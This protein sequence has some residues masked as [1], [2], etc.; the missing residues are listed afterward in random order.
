M[1]RSCAM[2]KVD[3]KNSL[4]TGQELM[5]RHPN[6]KILRQLIAA[7]ATGCILFLALAGAQQS[8]KGGGRTFPFPDHL[9]MDKAVSVILGRASDTSV[10]VNL[11]AEEAVEAFLEYGSESG[12]Y[13]QKTMPITLVKN[14]P[15]ETTLRGLK[16]NTRYVYRLQTR[17]R[18][19]SYEA[20]PEC[21]F[22][23]Q[24]LPGSEFVFC[25]QG[26]SHPERPNMS[27]PNL[28]ARTLQHASSC[29]PDLYF[30]MGD[31]FSVSHVRR[32]DD[33]TLAA[34]Y[35]LQR[36]FLG[37]VAKSASLYLVNGNHEQAS[38]FNYNQTDVRRQVAIGV[39]NARNKLFPM[40]ATEGI[41]T[42][43]AQQFEGIGLLRD[44]Y[45][46][47]WGDSLFV[48]LDNYWHSPAQVDSGF[49][50]AAE[51]GSGKKGEDKK[52]EKKN[53]DKRN[54]D[55][56]GISLGD[57]QYRWFKKTLETSNAKFKFVFAHHVLGTGR[58]GVEMSNLYEW[59]GKSKS[60]TNEFKQ[61][62][63]NWELPI[64]P[65]MVKHGVTIFFHGHDH[66]FARQ[67]R[68]GVIY[69][70]A[71]LPADP[72]YATHNDDAYT[73]T[74][75]ANSG[76]LRVTVSPERTKV[77]YVRCWLPKDETATQKTGHI[78]HSY[79]IQAKGK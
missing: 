47:T 54:R 29:R 49:D 67:E 7:I 18:D 26:D 45:A 64:H 37:L 16:P 69:Q 57:E 32:V 60:G 25:V 33:I 3:I 44:Y 17:K 41:Y 53:T 63:P 55:W 52:A 76:Y 5:D 48:V 68:D 61:K 14:Q 1:R 74:K 39:Q 73:G 34:P 20:R 28:Y 30:C 11:L 66:L 23:T 36:P 2:A 46:W 43:D 35:L 22:H 75:L 40:P 56:W 4:D 59:G 70:E 8:Q 10:T 50:L 12:K 65:L 38:L 58:G 77:D 9:S 21:E 42:G 79:T 19:G 27:E 72:F 6:R 24:R 51:T 78:A 31:D 13:N 71:P 15:V 62:R